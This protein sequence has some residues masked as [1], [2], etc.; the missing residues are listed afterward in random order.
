MSHD[1]LSVVLILLGC[2]VGVVVLF[3]RLHLPPILGYLI[4]GV[5]IGPRAAGL[6]PETEA[7]RLLAEFGVVFLMFSVGLEF[8]LPQIMNMRRTVFGLGGAQVAAIVVLG[9]CAAAAAGTSW[10]EGVIV[11]GVIAMWSTAIVS[12]MLAERMPL[13]TH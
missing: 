6:V 9:A 10:R 1:V 12:R 7:Q 13:H 5:V 8:S 3:R 4:V 11:G 2:A